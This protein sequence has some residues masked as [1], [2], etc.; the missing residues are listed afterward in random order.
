MFRV[1]SKDRIDTKW[2]TN[3][4][5]ENHTTNGSAGGGTWVFYSNQQDEVEAG[6]AIVFKS[7]FPKRKSST[8]TY[9]SYLINIYRLVTRFMQQY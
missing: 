8:R 6:K 5:Q 2:N 9:I 4:T 1:E 7:G 3:T